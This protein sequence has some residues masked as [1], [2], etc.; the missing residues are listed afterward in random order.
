[1]AMVSPKTGEEAGERK[2]RETVQMRQEE[3]AW[4]RTAW[5]AFE[6]AQMEQK[7]EKTCYT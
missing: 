4:Q 2:S 6:D 3:R 5:K 1:M 7:V